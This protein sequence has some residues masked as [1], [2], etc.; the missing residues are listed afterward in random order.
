MWDV[1][2]GS[3]M[4]WLRDRWLSRRK[5]FAANRVTNR[6]D[7]F[8]PLRVALLLVRLPHALLGVLLQ[9]MSCH[10]SKLRADQRIEQ[11]NVPL[12]AV[13]RS[14]SELSLSLTLSHILVD[15]AGLSE[16]GSASSSSLSWLL[17]NGQ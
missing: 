12:L 5:P 8:P 1:T 9:Q 2:R 3:P 15:D 4:Q 17:A 7:L 6:A 16:M 14:S 10:F 11:A 13:S